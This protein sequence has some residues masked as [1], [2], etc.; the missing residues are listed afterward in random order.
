VSYRKGDECHKTGRNKQR[1]I[2]I[3]GRLTT[4]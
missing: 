4:C 1:K 3:D 2:K